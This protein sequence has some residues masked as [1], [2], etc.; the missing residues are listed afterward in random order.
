[1]VRAFEGAYGAFV[2]TNYWVARTPEEEAARTRAEME[3]EQAEIAARAAKAAGVQHVIWSTLEDTRQL[4]ARRP[5][6]EYRR[7][8]QGPALRCQG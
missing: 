2:V 5:C 6:A 1:M 8:V 4:S 7:A 3:L